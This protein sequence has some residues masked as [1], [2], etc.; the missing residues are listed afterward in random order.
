MLLK[1]LQN[2]SHHVQSKAFVEAHSGE[3]SRNVA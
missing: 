2:K 1:N 3:P